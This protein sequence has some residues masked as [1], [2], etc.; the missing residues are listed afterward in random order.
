VIEISY[1][2]QAGDYEHGGDASRKL[3]EHLKQIGASPADIRR[4]MI[5]S[6]EAEMNVV[7]HSQGGRLLAYVEQDRLD[8]EICDVGPGIADIEQAMKEGYSTASAKARE[9]GFG[10][11]LGLPN[12]CKNSDRFRIE[13]SAGR[14]TRIC[15]TI[16]LKPSGAAAERPHSILPVDGRC[17]RC[18]N[19]LR[20]C[21]TQAM[22]VRPGGPEIAD[23]LCIDC[24][25]CIGSCESGALTIRDTLAELGDVADATLVLPT[26]LL[27]QFGPGHGPE[28][29]LGALAKL[30][31]ARITVTQA[32]QIA[33]QQA[34]LDFARRAK[35]MN[36]V[37]P[38]CPAVINLIQTRF[39]ALL[40]NIAPFVPPIEAV[41]MHLRGRRAMF[42]VACPS[43]RSLLAALRGG[44]EI[45][46]PSVLRAA[47]M[48]ML[49]QRSVQTA[50]AEAAHDVSAVTQD[51][52]VLRVTGLQHVMEVLEQVENGTIEEVPVLELWACDEG[53][54]GSQ[55]LKEDAY[56]A[57]RRYAAWGQVAP[58]EATIISRR[59]TLA[60][61]PGLRLDEEMAK[62]IV[63]FATIDTI[64]NGLPGHDCGMCGC[65]TCRTLAEDV[66][67]GLAEI[68]A[69][70]HLTG[71]GTQR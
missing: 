44:V 31:F 4:T 17:K 65:P 56:V 42:A 60:A 70:P 5:A 63:K 55:L 21:A 71:K 34:V 37:S 2:I 16:F 1:D 52:N 8:V 32:S 40:R 27:T 10:A 7:I 45:I 57:A 33:L 41:A 24:T 59:E 48:P 39:P 25:A 51:E 18:F 46:Q 12:I 26:A 13:S 36:V 14:G 58:G 35:I 50:H 69:C 20:A 62:A 47:L 54:F 22:R 30:P 53:C 9:F 6:Y 66:V 11:G 19:C 67:L 64:T 15:F 23:H 68:A 38:V 3:K 29:V 28:K 61:R 43:Q 49:G